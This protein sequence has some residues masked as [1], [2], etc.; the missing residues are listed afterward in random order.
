M[1]VRVSGK[2]GGV[3]GQADRHDWNKLTSSRGVMRGTRFGP[4]F[5]TGP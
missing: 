4:S 1:R 5:G 2:G 3:G